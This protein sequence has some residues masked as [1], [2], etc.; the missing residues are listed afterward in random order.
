ME[1]SNLINND[2]T[3]NTDMS[4]S[5]STIGGNATTNN[6]FNKDNLQEVTG[7]GIVT[8]STTIVYGTET[9]QTTGT[10]TPILLILGEGT[11]IP[12][13]EEEPVL[14]EED[15]DIT[16]NA[17]INSEYKDRVP[18][19]KLDG[20]EVSYCDANYV[21]AVTETDE[22][23]PVIY[24]SQNL[25]KTFT[26][27]GD[28]WCRVTFKKPLEVKDQLKLPLNSDNFLDNS[29]II[30][31][32]ISCEENNTGQ[33]RNTT[34]TF[35]IKN[36]AISHNIQMNVIQSAAVPGKEL[37][38]CLVSLTD[39]GS[40]PI[41]IL[42]SQPLYIKANTNSLSLHGVK[43]SFLYNNIENTN[44]ENF[45]YFAMKDANNSI[46]DNLDII[47]DDKNNDVLDVSKYNITTDDNNYK[48]I[49]SKSHNVYG[50]L[51]TASLLNCTFT[52]IEET[53]TGTKNIKL[54]FNDSY[55][56]D[57]TVLTDKIKPTTII[58]IYVCK[59]DALSISNDTR[60][61]L[62]NTSSSSK[63]PVNP[64]E[65][66]IQY[67]EGYQT[68]VSDYVLMYTEYKN[69]SEGTDIGTLLSTGKL[70]HLSG[71]N[72]LVTQ[73]KY[74]NLKLAN[75]SNTMQIH[76]FEKSGA[77]TGVLTS[78]SATIDM[79]L[80]VYAKINSD[81]YQYMSGNIVNF[82]NTESSNHLG[83]YK[84]QIAT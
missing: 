27:N 12:D 29:K 65:T 76:H 30:V 16:Y 28:N 71:H 58:T 7:G 42:N 32:V 56:R 23:I 75:I 66:Y 3:Y 61:A 25:S 43:E 78:M 82:S 81:Y 11:T 73:V 15:E 4:T 68:F 34:I 64:Y 69:V 53:S 59:L 63:I 54:Y 36:F 20:S 1:E 19:I 77:E 44:S 83:V 84:L 70:T 40:A 62:F 41:F 48:I 9:S 37:T 80:Y 45:I 50:K 79:N 38:P 18:T 17:V 57:I 39:Y 22:T 26:N 49:L 13:V 24:D 21:I 35:N 67:Q 8:Q 31:P 55:L 33:E 6:K 2:N 46:I 72:D 10:L 5:Q 74:K 60:Y 51:G 47:K 14:L 52:K